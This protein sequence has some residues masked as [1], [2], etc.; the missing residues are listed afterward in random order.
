MNLTFIHINYGFLPTT[1]IQLEKQKL[2]L[3]ESIVTVKSVENKLEHI[4]D[5]AGTA[6]KEKLKNVLKKNCGFNDLKKISSIL[7]GESTSI[8]G[9]PEDLNGN[10]LA[11]FKYATSSDVERS[12]SRYK[13]VLTDNRR[14]IKIENIK[15]VLVIQCNTFTD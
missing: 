1:I 9:L 7:T 4:I 5:E 3:H 8:E 13:N 10:D 12:F 6:I 14:L 11:H 15:K 2:P